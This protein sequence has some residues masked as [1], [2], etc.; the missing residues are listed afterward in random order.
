MMASGNYSSGIVRAKIN[1]RR[2]GASVCKRFCVQA[3]L[4][5]SG[6]VHG[7]TLY[8]RGKRL[9]KVSFHKKLLK[10]P[11]NPPKPRIMLQLLAV[12]PDYATTV[13]ALCSYST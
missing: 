6:H 12:S 10:E 1:R 2:F 11:D 13:V 4:C 8:R 9:E 7:H 3:L 5:A